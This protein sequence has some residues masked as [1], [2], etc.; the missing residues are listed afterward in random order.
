MW[1]S[2]LVSM[3]MMSA[4][5]GGMDDTGAMRG[6]ISE[7]KSEALQHLAFARTATSLQDLRV[8]AE[9]YRDVLM[10]MMADMDAMMD[11]MGAHCGG[12]GG[13]RDMHAGLETAMAQHMAMMHA[14]TQMSS[15]RAEVERH[16]SATMSTMDR[17]DGMMGSMNCW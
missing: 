8:D 7:T 17:M 15:A 10:P 16:A 5:H 13:M 4:C 11:G 9:R 3:F 12:M 6:F 2:T 14:T 1:K